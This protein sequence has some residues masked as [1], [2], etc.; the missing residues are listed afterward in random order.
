[1]QNA[2]ER[3]P[4]KS[5]V[6]ARRRYRATGEAYVAYAR[7]NRNLFLLAFGPY[8]DP[9]VFPKEESLAWQLLVGALNDLDSLGY[10]DPKIRPYAEILSWS[11]IHGIS[12]LVLDQLL[13]DEAVE[14]LLDSLELAIRN[15]K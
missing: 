1:M 14:P 5:L 13:P 11:S 6:A 4:G 2:V 10:I 7:K 15:V 8:C 9:T 12:T 3:F